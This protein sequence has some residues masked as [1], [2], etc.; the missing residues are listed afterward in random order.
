MQSF[1][2]QFEA[3]CRIYFWSMLIN[4]VILWKALLGWTNEMLLFQIQFSCSCMTLEISL[5]KY[6]TDPLA[7]YLQDQSPRIIAKYQKRKGES[8]API[9]GGGQP[10]IKLSQRCGKH[11]F[12]HYWIH[13]MLVYD[14]FNNGSSVFST[15]FVNQNLRNYENVTYFSNLKCGS[16]KFASLIHQLPL[17]R[18]AGKNEIFAEHITCAD[19]NVYVY[20]SNLFNV[21]LMHGKIPQ[22]CM[23]TVIVPICT[24]RNS[25]ISDAGQ[26]GP[27]SRTTL[28][29]KLFEH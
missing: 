9:H 21:C 26:Y 23:K 28:I 24:N 2:Y 5:K 27:A 25:D 11:A 7:S 19:P 1:H 12:R 10:E 14:E 6:K 8:H 13:H 3:G 17:N 18:I 15:S 20:L 29:S 16:Y 22:R 4:W